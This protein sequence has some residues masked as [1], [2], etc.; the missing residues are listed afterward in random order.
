MLKDFQ[1]KFSPL[2]SAEIV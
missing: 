1:K 2:D